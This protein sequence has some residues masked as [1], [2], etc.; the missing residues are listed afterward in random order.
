MQLRASK[1]APGEDRIYT[2]GEKE[3]LCWLDRKDKG[4]PVGILLQ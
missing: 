2:D 3:Y 4:V 1:L